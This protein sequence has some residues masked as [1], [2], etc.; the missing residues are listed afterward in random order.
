MI[1]RCFISVSYNTHKYKLCAN[2]RA[3]NT[4][5]EGLIITFA[6]KERS[7]DVLEID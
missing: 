5:T 7:T 2:V 6:L 3:S 4:G 1:T